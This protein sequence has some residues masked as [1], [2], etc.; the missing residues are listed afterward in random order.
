MIEDV[1]VRPLRPACKAP[2][3]NDTLEV[4]DIPNEMLEVRREPQGRRQYT[5]P[6]MRNGMSI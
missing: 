6:Q 4:G 1:K 5:N 2:D 3:K